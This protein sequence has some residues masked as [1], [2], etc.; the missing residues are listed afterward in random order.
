MVIDRAFILDMCIPCGK[1]FFFVPKL[2]SNIKVKNFD[3]GHNFHR[4][5]DR[6]FLFH[7]CIAC[8]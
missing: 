7:M 3:T 4:V 2:R 6:A 8:G 5:N 1:I